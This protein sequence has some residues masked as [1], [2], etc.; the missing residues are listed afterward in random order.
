V[1]NKNH[2]ASHIYFV[3]KVKMAGFSSPQQ[4]EYAFCFPSK[5]SNYEILNFG[6]KEQLAAAF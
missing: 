6:P 4:E 5:I 2:F 1:P 3:I